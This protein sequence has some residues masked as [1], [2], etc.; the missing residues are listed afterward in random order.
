[1][2]EVCV[3]VCVGACVFITVWG[4]LLLFYQCCGDIHLFILLYPISIYEMLPMLIE[5]LVFR[6]GF[7]C[8]ECNECLCV[9][10]CVC[11]C[12]CG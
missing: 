5:I 9:C 6:L 8:N 12:A 11:V 4:F 7:N 10:L 3:C 2:T 1:M